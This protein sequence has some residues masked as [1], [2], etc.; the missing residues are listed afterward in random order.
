MV[1]S[2]NSHCYP[3]PRT[4][5]CAPWT[6]RWGTYVPSCERGSKFKTRPR[7]Y[8]KTAHWWVLKHA[9]AFFS[10][11]FLYLQCNADRSRYLGVSCTCPSWLGGRGT[12]M[13]KRVNYG[14]HTMNFEF[15]ISDWSDAVMFRFALETEFEPASTC[16]YNRKS[17]GVATISWILYGINENNQKCEG[18][19]RREHTVH[20]PSRNLEDLI[21]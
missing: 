8:R 3:L 9:L 11:L 2:W 18:F 15:A 1:Q 12:T 17:W 19:E 4:W 20:I 5:M 7:G 10:F 6:A 16:Y 14:K 13:R 21:C